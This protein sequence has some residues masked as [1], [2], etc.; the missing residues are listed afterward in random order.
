[1]KTKRTA[2]FHLKSLNITAITMNIQVLPWNGHNKCDGMKRDGIKNFG[3][4]VF[5]STKA[6]D[7]TVVYVVPCKAHA[8]WYICLERVCNRKFIFR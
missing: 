4:V 8:M 5:Q 2:T 6:S 1:M 3:C 7:T